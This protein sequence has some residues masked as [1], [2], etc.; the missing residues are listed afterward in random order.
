MNELLADVDARKKST[1]STTNKSLPSDAPLG[2]R[3]NIDRRDSDSN[4]QTVEDE[5]RETTR[6]QKAPVTKTAAE[7]KE[8]QD[9]LKV[10]QHRKKILLAGQCLYWSFIMACT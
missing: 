4:N 9:E 7:K 8:Q 10:Q 1:T 2:R 3:K 5:R 6:R